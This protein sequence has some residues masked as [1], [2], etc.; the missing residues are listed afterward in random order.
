[1]R[2]NRSL[3]GI[4]WVLAAPLA[5]A[6]GIDEDAL[7]DKMR[8]SM[9]Q[10]GQT[11]SPDQELGMRLKIR[12]MQDRMQGLANGGLV[13][14]PAPLAAPAVSPS[15]APPPG[16]RSTADLA[17]QVAAL[18][19]PHPVQT[20]P[21]RDG[22]TMEGRLLVDAEGPIQRAAVDPLTGDFTYLV[23]RMDGSQVLKRGRGTAPAFVVGVL[24]GRPG[25]WTLQTLDG[26][27][28]AG[29]GFV[30][31]SQGALLLRTASAFEFLPGQAVKTITLP[32]GWTPVPLQRGDLA[33][34]R[35][36][37]LEKDASARPESGSLG[38]LF[39]S[40]KRLIGAETPDDYALWHLDS[41]TLSTL[42]L[43]VDGKQVMRV[44]DC[45]RQ[46]AIVN[47]CASAE[48]YESLW[49]PDGSRNNRH[50]F[51]QAQWF[52]TPSGPM[53]VVHQM[54]TKEVRLF[55]LKTGKQVVAFRRPLG[56]ARSE[57]AY[58]QDGRVTV[59]AQLGFS[60]YTLADARALLDQLPDQRGVE[61]EGSLINGLP[62]GATA[63]ASATP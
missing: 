12:G 46:N 60:T 32:V 54:G 52:N 31:T 19:A 18:P 43:S 16:A 37:L 27:T 49:T 8:S 5:A 4:V 41:G 26:Q 22:F 28:I 57:A 50:Y 53:G 2:I 61:P 14:P 15:V 23:P 1:M 62:E 29:D 45:R 30:T 17:K 3:A 6:Q 35:V 39:Q 25:Q 34:T 58:R 13:R 44:G 63:P 10:Q 7:I 59:T 38:Q 36:M 9:A 48:A 24:A 33:S 40:T 42:S 20:E 11:L 56:I 21:R 51:W 55:D 47:K